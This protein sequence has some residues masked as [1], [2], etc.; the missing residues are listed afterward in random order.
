MA[1]AARSPRATIALMLMLP[2]A[3]QEAPLPATPPAA[4]AMNGCRG[5]SLPDAGGLD[6][7]RA[8]LQRGVC[9]TA[10]FV[11]RL[12]EYGGVLFWADGPLPSDCCDACLGAS[13]GFEVLF[14][15][16]YDR[17]LRRNADA[18]E[19]STTR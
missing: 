3:A 7:M 8:G 5:E 17:V 1:A 19:G 14:G 10:R 18:H 4:R 11:D 6:T 9:S 13:I 2:A 16:A 12:F 15:D